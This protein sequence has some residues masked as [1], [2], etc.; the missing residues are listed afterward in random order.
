V[1]PARHHPHEHHPDGRA[2][3]VAVTGLPTSLDAVRHV[4]EAVDGALC[5]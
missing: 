1:A 4:E 3:V 5:D 2:A